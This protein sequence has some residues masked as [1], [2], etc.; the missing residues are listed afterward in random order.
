M[1]DTTTR[2]RRDRPRTSDR[3]SEGRTRSHDTTTRTDRSRGPDRPADR[4]RERLGNRGLERTL[5]E[6]GRE[7]AAGHDRAVAR[8]A[9]LL[10]SEAGQPLPPTTRCEMAARFGRDF[11][12]V[13][14]HDGPAA[15]QTA[16]EIDAAAYT[17]GSD[18]VFGEGFDPDRI[19]GRWLLAHELAHVAQQGTAV[20]RGTTPL[21]SRAGTTAE[22]EADRAA[23]AALTGRSVAVAAAPG[24]VIAMQQKKPEEELFGLGAGLTDLFKSGFGTI[25]SFDET[26]DE[27][28]QYSGGARGTKFVGPGF[29][30]FGEFFGRLSEGEDVL[31]ALG[32]GGT[33]GLTSFGL[34]QLMPD[35]G[36]LKSSGA[37]LAGSF[38]KMFGGLAGDTTLGDVLTG[39]GIGLDYGVK[40]VNPTMLAQQS[41]TEGI[42]STYNTLVAG[43]E[44]LYTGE[45]APIED[46]YERNLT[47]KSG[48]VIQGY[49]F[50]GEAL[51][52]LGSG[53]TSNLYD[54]SD[55]AAKGELGPLA[56]F[57]DWLGGKMFEV[58]N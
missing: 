46:L 20:P 45:T 57:G 43:G 49:T 2:P 31:T 52:S 7:N 17:V 14:I 47:G 29:D 28:D 10:A 30:V 41:T 58:F 4:L 18:I 34:S 12:G 56:E 26:L 55:R 33:K 22:A 9:D 51:S 50:I 19:G 38:L 23:M 6:R 48:D 3:R 54:L 24:A 27:A 40:A 42:M 15:A 53:D 1:S 13:R 25:K 44:A 21:L 37:G 32:A 16:R 5:A 36:G 35:S 8:V 39:T 11:G